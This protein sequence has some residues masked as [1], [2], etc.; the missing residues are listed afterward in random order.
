VNAVLGALDQ[1]DDAIKS[2]CGI[3]GVLPRQPRMEPE[4]DYAESDRLKNGGE[5]IVERTVDEDGPFERYWQLLSLRWA[6]IFSV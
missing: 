5:F 6:K 2:R 1:I 4:I 3:V